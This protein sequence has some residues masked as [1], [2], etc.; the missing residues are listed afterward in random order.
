MKATVGTLAI[1][2]EDL[3]NSVYYGAF[4]F[5]QYFDLTWPLTCVTS[6][7][8]RWDRLGR[9]HTTTLQMKKLSWKEIKGLQQDFL[10]SDNFGID[11][12]TENIK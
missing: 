11:Q 2:W 12:F 7:I 3:I 4:A 5:S 9:D 10:D 1:G 6:F 8:P